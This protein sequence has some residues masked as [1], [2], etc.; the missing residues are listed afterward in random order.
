MI[1]CSVP[2]SSDCFPYVEG[3]ALLTGYYVYEICGVACE[4]VFDV[5]VLASDVEVGVGSCVFA[6]PASWFVAGVCSWWW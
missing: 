3:G 1:T 4:V 2:E 5:V 6:D